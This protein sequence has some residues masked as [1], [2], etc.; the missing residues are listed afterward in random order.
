ME[1][2][3]RNFSARNIGYISGNP[4]TLDHTLLTNGI[5]NLFQPQ[6]IN[7]TTGIIMNET[8]SNSDSYKSSN[9]LSS[10]YSNLEMN[11][12]RKF[13]LVAGLRYEYNL[14]KLD[15]LAKA[16]ESVA[17]SSTPAPQ[18]DA[19]VEL[20]QANERLSSLLNKPK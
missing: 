20:N 5:E 9:I 10:V 3:D 17:P 19:T 18:P 16:Q 11:V 2:K 4:S 8:T 13:R 15:S 1:Y 7:A 6:N 14:Q 12:N